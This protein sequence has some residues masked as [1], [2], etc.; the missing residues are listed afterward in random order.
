M[1]TT[2][3]PAPELRE[4][5][6]DALRALLELHHSNP[7]IVAELAA[8]LERAAHACARIT[9]RTTPCA[10]CA[11][12]LSNAALL[13]AVASSRELIDRPAEPSGPAS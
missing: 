4:L 13:R 7:R 10:D 9:R 8:M 3:T 6:A 2:K 1:T 11:V 12:K 5:R